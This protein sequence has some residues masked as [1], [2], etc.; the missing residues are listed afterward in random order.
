MDDVILQKAAIIER[1]LRRVREEHAGDDTRLDDMTRL[2]AIVLNLQR[3][4]EAAIDLAMHRVRVHRLGVPQES[5]EAFAA[6]ARA[7]LLDSELATAMQRMVGFRNIAVHDYQALS[8]D[9]VKAILAGHL[10]ELEHFASESV[11]A[12]NPGA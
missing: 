2:D 11:A 3:A 6:L 9:I 1:C 12:S 7:G 8:L 4:C 5:R 10:G